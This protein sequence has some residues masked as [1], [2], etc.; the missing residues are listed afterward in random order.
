MR[1][2][3]TELSYANCVKVFEYHKA[4]YP[5]A[6][7][8]SDDFFMV[9]VRGHSLNSMGKK[10]ENDINI[11]D[12]LIVAVNRSNGF[13]L[14][15]KGNTDPSYF[16]KKLAMLSPGIIRY[17]RGKHKGDYAA[18]RPFPEG[19]R[20][21]CTRDGHS[22][23]CSHT[24]IHGGRD[25]ADGRGYD[26]WSA[27]C[28]TMPITFFKK[29]FQPLCYDQIKNHHRTVSDAGTKNFPLILLEKRVILLEKRVETSPRIFSGTGEIVL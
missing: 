5:H 14:A 22:S 12:D 13:Y 7:K 26:T 15:V 28:I 11:Y 27:G 24:N 23:D 16:S 25:I 2:D 18:F 10:N 21:P 6:I 3:S 4:K 8:E 29:E 17:Y 19:V 20:L 1:V 9:A